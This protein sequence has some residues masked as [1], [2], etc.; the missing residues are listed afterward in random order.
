MTH[1]PEYFKR[2]ELRAKT[3]RQLAALLNRML[4]R[5]VRL[6]LEGA[7]TD[8]PELSAG[9]QKAYTEAR[10]LLP[11][12]RDAAVAERRCIER[13]LACLRELLDAG[14]FAGTRVSAACP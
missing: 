1:S 13:E 6:A 9:A 11:L 5:G 2:M 3:D 14:E 12:L 4:A 10:R 8:T 7:E